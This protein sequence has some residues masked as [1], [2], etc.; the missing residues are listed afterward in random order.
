MWNKTILYVDDDDVLRERLS[1]AFVA[2]G[3]QVI[4]AAS[5]DEA[6]QQ[7]NSIAPDLALVDLRMPGKSGMELLKELKQR[8]PQT[9]TVVLTGYGSI[10]NAVDAMQ[11]GALSY[12]TK[13]AD[14]DQILEAFEQAAE[15]SIQA[16]E[17]EMKRP[18]LAE[19]E[20]NHIQQVLADCGGNV[21]HAAKILDIPRRTLQRKLKKRAP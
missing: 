17:S 15:E 3:L 4:T 10:A 20:W 2:R 6:T 19:T 8:S 16:A 7:L 12:V 11:L 9:K 21:T 13:P 14:A 18:S 5:V 1:R